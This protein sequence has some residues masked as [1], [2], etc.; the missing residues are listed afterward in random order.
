MPAS[1]AK[2]K[3]IDK[4]RKANL[5]RQTVTFNTKNNID[6]QM[7]AFL[8]KQP[9]KNKFIKDLILKEMNK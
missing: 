1:K 7:L 4:Y 8:D 9:S 3:Y 6:N 5:K 2:I